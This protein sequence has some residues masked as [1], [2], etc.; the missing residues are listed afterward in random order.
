MRKTISIYLALLLTVL[1]SCGP[2]ATQEQAQDE[3]ETAAPQPEQ[4][5]WT[6]LF[7]GSN[8][9]A[10]RTFKK[11]QPADQWQIQD[12]ALMLTGKGGGDLITKEEFEN[13]ELTLDWKI[14]E[15][16][17]SGLFF[18]VVEADTLKATY[19]SGPEFQLLDND[20]HPDAKIEK[21]RAGDNYDLQ[22]S[23]E[24]TVKPVGEWNSI[25]LVVNDGQ[26]QHWMN[27]TKVIE[28]TLWT[29][30]W[31]E[32]VANS[33][34]AQFPAYGKARQGHIALQDHGDKVW[35]KDIKIRRL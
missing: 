12:D 23:T 34:F 25:R 30:E 24:E 4:E 20:C 3:P 31:E 13:F 10:W 21:H 2:S 26:V 11:E 1:A 14:S 18:N 16:G 17:N 15:C 33:K 5:E 35:F 29:P 32:Q 8:L 9:D 6:V 19:H 7:D 28:Y 22:K 27:G